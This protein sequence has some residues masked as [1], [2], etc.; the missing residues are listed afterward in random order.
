MFKILVIEDDSEKLRNILQT[1]SSV[2]GIDID[3]IEHVIDSL[4]AKNKLKDVYY[5]LLIL[6]IAI[7]LKK[8]EPIDIEG[9][10]KLLQE[11]TV[12]DIYKT[13][14]HII[15]L[16]AR[17]EIFSK[18]KAEF[19]SQVL[20][21]I[22]YS[23]TDIEWQKQLCRGVEY[24][25]ISKLSSTTI[26]PE[27]DYDIAIITALDKEFDAVKSLS[28]TWKRVVVKNDSSPY[29]KTVFS[30]NKKSFTVI[31]ACCPQMGMNS[32][33]VLSMKLI[34]NFRPKFLFMPGIS[35]SVKNIESHGYGDVIVIDEVWDGGAGKITQKEDG[36]NV[37]LPNA[38]HLRLDKDISESIRSLKDNSS[39]LR[40][41]KDMW[42]PNT[43]PN[44]ELS[45]HIGSVVSVAG[46][47]ENSAV[48]EQLKLEDRKL[49][50]LE[51]EA[52]GMYYSAYNCSNPKPTAI[53]LKGISD[54]ANT[55]KNDFFQAYASYTSA[56]VMYEFIM[57]EL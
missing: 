55:S 49:L 54:F 14:N 27:Y 11:I 46:V 21:V 25:L 1:L 40:K 7:P 34:H 20:S 8:S 45:L 37:F 48:I 51:M 57:T 38:H 5:D 12:R 53:A 36:T 39:L 29:F 43:V 16:T 31:A 9:G 44:T 33:A 4:G 22:R 6:D 41:I 35:A 50:G 56:M 28:K 13:P 47:I 32:C 24:R 15:G 17:D 2:D 52:Y 3:T 19:D 26:E 30:R 42:K 18:A 23:E 10:I